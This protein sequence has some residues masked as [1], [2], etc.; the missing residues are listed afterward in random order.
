MGGGGGGGE[1]GERKGKKKTFSHFLHWKL[2][3]S[4]ALR[5]LPRVI[6]NILLI[7]CELEN[8]VKFFPHRDLPAWVLIK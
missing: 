8:K 4:T 3:M 5:W 2:K 7:E 1:G 6:T